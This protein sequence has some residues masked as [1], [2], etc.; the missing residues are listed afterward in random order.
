MTHQDLCSSQGVNVVSG[1]LIQKSTVYVLILAMMM[2][3]FFLG[4][5]VTHSSASEAQLVQVQTVS[6]MEQIF[7][8]IYTRISPSVVSISVHG[9]DSS[10]TFDA[11]GTGFVIDSLGHIVTNAHVAADAFEIV[12]NFYD[13]TIMRA[14][15][16]G[17]D[18]DS[19]LAVLRVNL[20]AEQLHPVTFAD[21]D[22]LF[23]GETTLAIGS[24]FGQR[25]TLTSGIISALERTIQGLSDYSIGSVIQTDAAINPG[26][27]GGPLL[28]MQGQVIGVNSQIISE[29]RSS[30]GIGF[31]IPSNLVQ[32]VASELVE[33]GT[34][35]Y[36]FMGINGDEVTLSR[37]EQL[38]LP[39]NLRGVVVDNVTGGGPAFMGGLRPDDVITAIDSTPM[40]GMSSLVAYLASKTRPGQA[41]SLTVWRAGQ[42]FSTT[43]TLGERP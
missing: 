12:V 20:P 25:W 22:T 33:T 37:I 41:V 27:S 24:P 23:I 30:A 26:N 18:L 28:N 7:S 40:T 21:S 9:E 39:N 15:L 10:G 4:T 43:V 1:K 19:D 38:G 11:G 32:R 31:A 17:M 8:D 36:S 13:G 5:A 6:D 14:D 2:F 29:S 35:N 34:V 16:V 3:A 42:L